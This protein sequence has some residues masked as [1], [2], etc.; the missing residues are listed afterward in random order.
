MAPAP[1]AEVK[2]VFVLMIKKG[3]ERGS[4]TI[5]GTAMVW[6]WSLWCDNVM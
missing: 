2:T 4:A 3:E 1:S 6:I 5:A